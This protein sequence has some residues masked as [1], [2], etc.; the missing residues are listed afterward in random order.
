MF[1]CVLRISPKNE[2]MIEILSRSYTKINQGAPGDYHRNRR[3]AVFP[4][5]YMP[6]EKQE[7]WQEQADM[8]ALD[9]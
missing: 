2:D 5:T 6:Q 7:G 4:N 1:Q 9:E 3:A 8:D